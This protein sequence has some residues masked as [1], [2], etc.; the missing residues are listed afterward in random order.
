M[1]SVPSP[2]L[3]RPK[4]S[5]LTAKHSDY[6]GWGDPLEGYTGVVRMIPKGSHSSSSIGEEVAGVRSSGTTLGTEIEAKVAGTGGTRRSCRV[7]H[8]LPGLYPLLSG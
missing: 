7:V 1:A 4:G 2:P 5:S 6:G 8:W 3:W